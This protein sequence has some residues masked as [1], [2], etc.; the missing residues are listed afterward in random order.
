MVLT[1]ILI[2]W[3]GSATDACVWTEALAKGFSVPAEFY[4]LADAE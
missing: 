4:Y 1:Y 3:E 2:G